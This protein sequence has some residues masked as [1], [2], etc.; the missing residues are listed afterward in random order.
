[1]GIPL[2]AQRTD[3]ALYSRIGLTSGTE[4]LGK[5]EEPVPSSVVSVQANTRHRLARIGWILALIAY[6][7]LA[8]HLILVALAPD[9]PH[10]HYYYQAVSFLH[11]SVAIDNAP[12]YMQ[13]VVTVNGHKY[14]P[15]G[16]LPAVL[17]MPLVVLF[18]EGYREA[19][20][21]YPL[22]AF[23]IWL[24]W[25]ILVRLGVALTSTRLWL[26]ALFFLGTVYF[27]AAVQSSGAWF[28]AHIVTCFFL[29]LGI[30][31]ALGRQRA[32]LMGIY[33]GLAAAARFTALF[34]FPFFLLVLVADDLAC[35]VDASFQILRRAALPV[36][37]RRFALFGL[38]L[39]IPLSILFAYNYVRFNSLTDSG[40]GAA[41]LGGDSTLDKARAYGLFSLAHVPKNL[42]YFFLAVPDPYG[43]AIKENPANSPVLIFPFLRPSPWGM[44]ILLTTPAVIYALRPRLRQPLVPAC[45]GAIL[46]CAIPIFTYYG[47]G[48][49]QFGYRYALDFMPFVWLLIV[50]A[51]RQRR[52]CIG[53]PNLAL[54]LIVS[55]IVINLWGAYWLP[56]LRGIAISSADGRVEPHPNDPLAIW[57]NTT[58]APPNLDIWGIGKDSNGY[59][60]VTFNFSD[61]LTAGSSGLTQRISNQGTI[62]ARVDDQNNFTVV[63]SERATGQSEF[64]KQFHC[65][66]SR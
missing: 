39:A 32:P 41:V 4:S 24:G 34:T 21:V 53:K 46:L 29:F 42:Y 60:L 44:S 22:V 45:W 27:S 17:T 7:I 57:C 62:S 48:W 56:Y 38:G 43:A 37:A 3:L 54:W 64:Q 59:P 63:W 40:Y 66:F 19:F 1:M 9:A 28:S 2:T 5:L 16:P 55:G 20:L 52:L 65:D 47:I 25:R 30:Y 26:V 36:L 23:T 49:A 58:A 11:G 35:V 50:L 15:L 10:D 31:E 18:G 14:L 61:L 33:L 12:D 6:A 51:L 8:A 13:D